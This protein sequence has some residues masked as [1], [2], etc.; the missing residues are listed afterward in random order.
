MRKEY[1]GMKK[2]IV[3]VLAVILAAGA[4]ASC[5][6]DNSSGY[7]DGS[8]RI[9]GENYDSHGW[10]PYIDVTVKDS[11]ITQVEF[12]YMNEEDG[13]LK[14]ED[15]A[16]E[17]AYISAG[18]GTYPAEFTEKLEKALIEKQDATMVDSVTGATH[19]SDDFKAMMNELQE[20]MMK[21][22]TDTLIF[23]N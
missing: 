12:D 5:G 1:F 4:L 6:S 3:A 14:T 10:K 23:K 22:T 15:E 13:R 11:K 18:M 16:Y 8:Y 7:K 17:K 21:G 2:I 19:S 9:E 20:A